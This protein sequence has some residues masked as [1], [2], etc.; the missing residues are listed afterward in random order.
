MNYELKSIS[1]GSVF[2]NAIRI[3]VVVGF[4]VAIVSFFV[5]PNPNIRITLWWQKILAT[6]LFTL[7]YSLV[8]SAVLTLIAWLYNVWAANFRGVSVNLEQQE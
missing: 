5:L 7:V 6:L 1:P 4:I 8:V 2:F 3:F